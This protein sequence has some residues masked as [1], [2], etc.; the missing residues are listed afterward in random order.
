[1]AYDLVAFKEAQSGQPVNIN[2]H[3]VRYVLKIDEKTS[4]IVFDKDHSL[5]VD[6]PSRQYPKLEKIRKLTTPNQPLRFLAEARFAA[7]ADDA[8]SESHSRPKSPRNRRASLDP[9]PCS[10]L[11]GWSSSEITIV[12]EAPQSSHLILEIHRSRA[13]IFIICTHSRL[14]SRAIAWACTNEPAAKP[15]TVDV[16]APLLYYLPSRVAARDA[17]V[18]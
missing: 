9:F 13:V 12:A 10:R 11:I 14:N 5:V 18:A 16:A 17:P 8:R 6:E 1:M 4:R 2:P 3:L 15:P 7:S